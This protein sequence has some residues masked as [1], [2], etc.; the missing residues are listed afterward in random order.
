MYQRSLS[1][2]SKTKQLA[3]KFTVLSQ[4][5]HEE[6]LESKKGKTDKLLSRKKLRNAQLQLS[7]VINNNSRPKEGIN[8]ELK[9]FNRMSTFNS[10]DLSEMSHYFDN[11]RFEPSTNLFYVNL[12]E[13][14]NDMESFAIFNFDEALA[15][16]TRRGLLLKF[17]SKELK[18]ASAKNTNQSYLID[19]LHQTLHRQN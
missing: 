18:K 3:I 15:N 10:P 8:K 9:F 12:V 5:H 2:S 7:P 13:K 14:E 17:V 19:N 16:P 11:F 1:G 4:S 6:V